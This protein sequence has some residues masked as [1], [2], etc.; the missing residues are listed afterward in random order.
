MKLTSL[1]SVL[2]LLIGVAFPLSASAAPGYSGTYNLTSTTGSGTISV[3]ITRRVI[4]Y[5]FEC[6]AVLD[7][8]RYLCNGITK[9]PGKLY[10]NFFRLD[11]S[12]N[13]KLFASIDGDVNGVT[14]TG[15]INFTKLYKLHPNE[16]GIAIVQFH[17]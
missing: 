11:A 9:T 16:S 12:Y 7:G 15:P 2:P 8:Q 5:G 4:Q 3:T 1:A 17:N 6:K 14:V 13:Q 10:L